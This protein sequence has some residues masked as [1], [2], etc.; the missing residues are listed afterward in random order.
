MIERRNLLLIN[1][2]NYLELIRKREGEAEVIRKREG[3]AE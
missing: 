1:F 3:E 2:L